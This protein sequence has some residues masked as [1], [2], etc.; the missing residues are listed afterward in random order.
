MEVKFFVRIL[1]P[2]LGLS[3]GGGWPLGPGAYG[4]GWPL[5]Q[6]PG[7]EDV[8]GGP[9]GQLEPMHD[10]LSHQCWCCV[11]DLSMCIT[12]IVCSSLRDICY[13]RC[14]LYDSVVMFCR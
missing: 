6:G 2:C 3:Y 5:A 14:N 7:G 11:D 4:G 10:D 1:T 9:A 8:A 13:C 12:I